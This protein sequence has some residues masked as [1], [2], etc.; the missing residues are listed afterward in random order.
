MGWPAGVRGTSSSATRNCLR[1]WSM[2]RSGVTEIPDESVFIAKSA[3]SSDSSA[4]TSRMSAAAASGTPAISP[5]STTSAE[6]RPCPTAATE[7]FRKSMKPTAAIG[8]AVGDP[9]QKLG[10]SAIGVVESGQRARGGDGARQPR[11]RMQSGAEFFGNDAGLDH[12]HAG[13]AVALCGP[14]VPSCQ[15]RQVRARHPRCVPVGSSRSGRTWP[16]IDAFSARKRR[17][18]S[19]SATCSS[20]SS[21]FI[22]AA[23]RVR[24]AR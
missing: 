1:V 22:C 13:S 21:R 24:A 18:V 12:R 10:G 15:A 2:P 5:R 17:V 6:S 3:V 20:V 14:R 19:R 23:T 9:G 11:P 16:E 8:G 7:V 4:S